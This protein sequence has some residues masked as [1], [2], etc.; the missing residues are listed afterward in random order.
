VIDASHKLSADLLAEGSTNKLVS[1]T[2]KTTWN[3]KQD[4]I[5]SSNKLSSD[6]VDDTNHTHKFVTT[7][8]K[9]TWNSKQPAGS[10]MTLDTNQTATSKKTFSYTEPIVRGGQETILNVLSTRTNDEMDAMWAGR[11]KIG[12][13]NKTFLLGVYKQASLSQPAIC[14]IG[15]HSWSNSFEETD[16]A[17]EDIYLNP[18]GNKAVYI[19]SHDWRANTGWFKVQN[20]GTDYNG[21]TYCN[22]GNI[23]TPV[24]HEVATIS[25]S[26]TSATNETWSANKLNNTIGNIES[27]LEALR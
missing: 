10:Y 9:N 1:Q 22:R 11:M 14:G 17:W 27:L 24:W 3:N 5:N 6:L 25:D 15:A 12:N 21:K 4:E 7:A 16:A 23:Q 8:E 2:E 20:N 13:R 18:D 19:G 26:S